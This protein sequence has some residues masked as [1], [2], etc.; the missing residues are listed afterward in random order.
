MN[1]KVMIAG[2]LLLAILV[3]TTSVSAATDLPWLM[4]VGGDNEAADSV[5]L[6]SLDG[7]ANPIPD[8]LQELNGFPIR[9][10][11]AAGASLQTGEAA[12]RIE[13]S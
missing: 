9:V 11:G 5:E 8:C 12:P 4:V 2:T 10:T 3:A 13:L 1:A 7:I 6:L